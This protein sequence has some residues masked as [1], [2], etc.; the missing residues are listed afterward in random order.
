[1]PADVQVKL[2]RV[3]QEREFERVGGGTPIKAD[4]RIIA[5]TNRDLRKAV[6]EGKFRE[7]LF[8]RLNVFPISLPPLRER[9]ADIPLLV[10]F[11]VGKFASR[12]GGRIDAVEQGTLARLMGGP[13]SINCRRLIAQCC[14]CATS[15]KWIRK[16]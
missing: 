8:Y 2:L 12:T 5:A 10:K 6:K 16:K 14:C 7:D 4:V 9:T 13:L 15:K 3:L 11:L 1:V